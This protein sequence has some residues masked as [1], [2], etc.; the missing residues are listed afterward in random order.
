MHSVKMK[1]ELMVSV[2]LCIGNGMLYT[3][4]HFHNLDLKCIV[5][6]ILTQYT[7]ALF[8]ITSEN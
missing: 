6:T 7:T 2:V 3:S 8:I 1:M 5:H 4:I